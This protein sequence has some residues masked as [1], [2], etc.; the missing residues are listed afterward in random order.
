MYVLLVYVRYAHQEP[1]TPAAPENEAQWPKVTVQLPLYNERYV[2]R[3]AIEAMA[4]L[5]YPRDQLHIQILDDSTD[6]TTELISNRIDQL[7]AEGVR[8]D[9]IHRVN[10]AGYKAGALANA[11]NQTDGEFMAIFDA[12]FI[13]APDFLRQV[14]PHFL[15]DDG[16]GLVQTRWGHLNA[17]DNALTHSQELA[18]D[19]HFGVEQFARSADG[20]VMS[21]NGTGGVWRRS[22]IAEAGGWQSDTLTEDF[23]LSYRAQIAGWRFKYVRDVVVPGEIPAQISIYKQ[24]QARWAKGSIQVMLKLIWPLIRS[25]LSIRNRIMGVMQMMQYAVQMVVLLLLVLT[26][27]MIVLHGFDNLPL[28]LLSVLTLSAPL[29]YALGQ[30]ALYKRDWLRRLVYLPVLLLLGMGMACNN[31]RAVFSGL[32]GQP[33]EFKRTPKFHMSTISDKADWW[34]RSQYATLLG[35]PN[36]IGEMLLGLYSLFG[37]WAA[38]MMMPSMIPSM[39]IYVGACFL[40]VGWGLYDRWL[41]TRPMPTIESD[42]LHQPGR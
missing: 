28:G 9:L 15:S 2:A 42:A 30:Q 13:P 25:N 23:D 10:R 8:I 4:A 40:I 22:C 39:I 24:Q 37:L 41:L 7:R 32:L 16:I 31:G 36:I 29:T 1:V 20:I 18:F 6:D 19:G 17:A 14:I 12:D 5:D 26:P 35:T 27:P 3:R 21:F 34:V 11:F 38:I 33:G